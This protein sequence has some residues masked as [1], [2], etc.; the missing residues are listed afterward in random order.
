MPFFLHEKSIR[1]VPFYPHFTGEEREVQEDKEFVQDHSLEGWSHPLKP[2]SLTS[3]AVNLA[4]EFFCLTKVQRFSAKD[5]L[6]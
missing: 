5:S 6:M 3:E 2:G 4:T 1:I